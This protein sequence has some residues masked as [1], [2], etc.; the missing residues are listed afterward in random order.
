M[1]TAV[2]IISLFIA[3][4]F[5]SCAPPPLQ[6]PAGIKN[7]IIVDGTYDEIWENIIS[8]FS[9]AMI[10]VKN[11]EKSSGFLETDFMSVDGNI[12]AGYIWNGKRL[13]SLLYNRGRMRCNVFVKMISPQKTSVRINTYTEIY[14]ERVLDDPG[15]YETAKSTGKYESHLIEYLISKNKQ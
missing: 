6:E 11:I 7:E 12:L 15:D 3:M 8:Y 14:R 2:S 1:K 13:P 9:Q 10:P 5:V 4:L